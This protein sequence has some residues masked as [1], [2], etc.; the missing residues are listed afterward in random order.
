MDRLKYALVVGVLLTVT[1][2]LLIYPV[3][4]SSFKLFGD[5]A[6]L[7]FHEDGEVK[8]L[9][10]SSVIGNP[11]G[12]SGVY[13]KVGDKMTLADLTLLSAEFNL[14]SGDCAGGAP[15]FSVTFEGLSGHLFIYVGDA[16]NFN[17]GG[18]SKFGVWQQISNLITSPDK[19]FDTTQLGGTFYDTFSDAEALAGSHNILYISL[20][21][22]AGW[23]TGN[24]QIL[25][26]R[27]VQ[28][29]DKVL[30]PP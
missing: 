9:Q 6:Y 30:L 5:A 17:C 15:R 4:A 22:D 25:W 1:F 7:K 21:V 13:L 10:L 3:S 28:V 24:S 16:P 18:S 29:N 8:V 23:A 27:D 20:V 19:R 11:N 2:T 12:Y 26:F 14:Q